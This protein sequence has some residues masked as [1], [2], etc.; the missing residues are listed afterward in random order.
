ML[1]DT[2]V[3]N[4]KTD[5]KYNLIAKGQTIKFDGWFKVYRY[6]KTEEEVL[7][8]ANEGEKL[9]LKDIKNTKHTTQPPKRYNDG[10]LI[11]KMEADGIGRPSTRATILKTLVDR[12]YAI[13]GK[14]KSGSFI[15]TD[16]GMK[17]CEYLEP[18]FKNS[19]MDVKY[20]AQ[21]EEDLDL[22][23]D[24][25]KT[26]LDIVQN[27]YNVLTK[28][29]NNAK[30]TKMPSQ[31][32]KLVG[33]KC[34]VCKEGDIVERSGQYGIF[35][36]CN[37]YPVC[38]SVFTKNDDGTFSLKEKKVVTKVGRK[39]PE[40]GSDLVE[41]TAKKSGNKFIACSGFPRCKFVEK[42]D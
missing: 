33:Q 29:I 26:Y 32:Q 42:D 7:P 16:L 39:C 15:V 35:Y 38:K 13:K 2:V 37:K 20:T 5:S 31:E 1:V 27:V 19:F 22:I 25:K 40:C 21:M 10:S 11:I 28:E 12:N 23:A 18:R 3:Y 36:P 9:N 17:V 6:S 30:E 41:R 8:N 14:G 34:T 24:G 4:I